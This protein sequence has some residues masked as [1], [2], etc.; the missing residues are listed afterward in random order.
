MQI[1]VRSHFLR[2]HILKK[3]FELTCYICNMIADV[4]TKLLAVQEVQGC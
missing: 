1:D 2:E 4:L 3:E